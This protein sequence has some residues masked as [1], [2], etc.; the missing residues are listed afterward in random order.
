ML[1][2]GLARGLSRCLGLLASLVP[3][4]TCATAGQRRRAALLSV[5]AIAA[6]SPACAAA[7]PGFSGDQAFYQTAWPAYDTSDLLANTF[8]SVRRIQISTAYRT[9][10]FAPESAPTEAE[11]GI[12]EV[13]ASAVDT[14]TFLRERAATAVMLSRS[15]EYRV[16]LLTVNHALEFPDTIVL[17]LEEDE[18]AGSALPVG[19][20]RVESISIKIR[21][22]NVV[23]G[24]TTL[25]PFEILARDP[26][27]DLALVGVL[28]PPDPPPIAPGPGVL[29]LPPPRTPV[30]SLRAGD[31]GRLSWGSFVYVMGY[32]R[33]Y[34]MVTRGIVSS[35]NDRTFGSFLVD[36]LWNR[37]MSGGLILAVRGD[38]E[39]L[40]WVGI[41]RSA[42]A[43]AEL[44]LVPEERDEADRRAAVRL[45]Y[46][47]EV[48]VEEV[49]GIDYGITLS[50]PMS[51]IRS[52]LEAQRIP[53][54]QA[55]YF[56]PPI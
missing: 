26:V 50:V 49:Q 24:S 34:P 25:D 29:S 18:E 39:G 56:L 37:G 31:A 52:F 30:L 7:I 27:R 54:L 13:F 23:V 5:L 11:V 43:T 6:V 10:T 41:A 35:P 1:S 19:S 47:G 36:G 2:E 40:E 53:L 51:E 48:Y 3:M 55:G 45:P 28:E 20:R 17:L 4:G 15:P 46:R 38:G 22:S 42:A 44:R 8:R 9:F 21:Q 14:S 12:P 16:A 33:G 32:P